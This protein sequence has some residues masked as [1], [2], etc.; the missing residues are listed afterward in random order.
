MLKK[1]EQRRVD[2]FTHKEHDAFKTLKQ[3][4]AFLPVL[5]LQRRKEHLSFDED[6]AGYQNWL[7]T[8]ARTTWQDEKS[9]QLLVEGAER[10]WAELQ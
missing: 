10:G 3:N 9:T 4:L 1:G 8:K 7:S 2:H 6:A 5:V